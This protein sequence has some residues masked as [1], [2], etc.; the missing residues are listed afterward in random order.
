MVEETAFARCGDHLTLTGKIGQ[1]VLIGGIAVATTALNVTAGALTQHWALCWWVGTGAGLSL[2]IVFEVALARMDDV[3]GVQEA[4]KV[5]VTGSLR[6]S[7]LGSSRQS[8][9]DSDIGG[10]LEQRQGS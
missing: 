4:R 6:Q 8:V 1:T 5:K 2:L 9:E 3:K 10:D 7:T